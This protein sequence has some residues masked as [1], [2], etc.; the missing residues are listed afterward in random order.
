RRVRADDA[1]GF[2]A[3]YRPRSFDRCHGGP[4]SLAAAPHVTWT[5][6]PGHETGV[7]AGRDNTYPSQQEFYRIAV[8]PGTNGTMSV[9][10]QSAGL[11]LLSPYL[12]VYN[13]AYQAIGWDGSSGRTATVLSVTINGVRP[14][15][16]YYVRVTGA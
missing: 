11:S 12:T 9:K 10:V 5:I 16:I 15:Q 14:G 1:A 8:P 6:D 3:I 7:L 13:A 2:R 4:P